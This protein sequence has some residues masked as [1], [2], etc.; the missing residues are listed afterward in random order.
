MQST[1]TIFKGGFAETSVID[2]RFV[3]K[4]AFVL[5]SGMFRAATTFE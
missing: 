2:V 1:R 3:A 4:T 5:L